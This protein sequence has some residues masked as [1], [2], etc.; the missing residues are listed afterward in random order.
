ML[1]CKSAYPACQRVRN[2]RP[3]GS[4]R[5]LG[6]T[7]STLCWGEGGTSKE[8]A[9]REMG[10]FNARTGT[11]FLP[12]KQT[13]VN[14]CS[15]SQHISFSQSTIVHK[16]H[17]HTDC[18]SPGFQFVRRFRFPANILKGLTREIAP[19]KS[20]QVTSRWD[21]PRPAVTVCLPSGS[22][23]VKNG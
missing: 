16:Q 23:T 2:K 14:L 6:S 15:L 19:R 20:Q 22:G 10:V 9:F 13:K 12:W 17:L 5:A 11:K 1:T 21:S 7:A 3:P 18:V 4:G 8:I